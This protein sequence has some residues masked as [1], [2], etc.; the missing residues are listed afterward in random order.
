MT[1]QPTLLKFVWSVILVP[2]GYMY[3][4]QM[5]E[6]VVAPDCSMTSGATV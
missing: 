1:V 4:D 3:T 5:S 2:V 6:A